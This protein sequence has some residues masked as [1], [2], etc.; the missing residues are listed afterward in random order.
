MK[1]FMVLIWMIPL[2]FFP[3]FFPCVSAGEC[4]YGVVHA[5]FR[6]Q[7]RG[8]ENATAHPCLSRGDV[9]VIHVEVVAT[10][11]LQMFFVKLH[12]FGTPVFEV[13]TGSTQM[14][15]LLECRQQI[16]A[17][18]RFSYQWTIRVRPETSWVSGYAP[19]E[20]FVQFNIND[21]AAC[22]V[23]FDVV[24][25]Y[26]L[27]EAGNGSGRE[28]TIEPL[29]SERLKGNGLPGCGDVEMITVMVLLVVLWKK[30]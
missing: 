18:Q 17:G 12:E 13:L 23:D 22:Q 2:L 15:Q 25:A 9:F 10:M 20:V 5:W 3:W 27:D 11:S 24:T 1:P 28:P 6:Y 8:W 14:E 7:D 29:G 19:L 26:I 30:R 16:T 21:S 4:C